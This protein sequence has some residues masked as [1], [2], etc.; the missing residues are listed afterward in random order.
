MPLKGVRLNEESNQ[1]NRAGKEV[2]EV[3]FFFF[4][5]LVIDIFLK[6]HKEPVRGMSV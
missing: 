2:I 6:K 5:E 3:H 1:V 4:S